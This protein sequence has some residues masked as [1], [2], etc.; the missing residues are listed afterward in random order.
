[1]FVY[2]K[3]MRMNQTDQKKETIQNKFFLR[4]F[5]IQKKLFFVDKNL[6]KYHDS[7]CSKN[8][9]LLV[10]YNNFL[11]ENSHSTVRRTE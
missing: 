1:V 2:R 6:K 5:L 4:N 11:Q 10:E 7:V 9:Q 3:K 8:I